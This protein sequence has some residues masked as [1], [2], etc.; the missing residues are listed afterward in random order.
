MR[1]RVILAVLASAAIG[2]SAVPLVASQEI[3]GVCCSNDGH[4]PTAYHCVI[5]IG[6]DCSS[7]QTG[8]C[9]P[10]PR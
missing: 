5:K 4:C 6:V 7:Q 9:E 2:Y 1:L 3:E 10:V 8:Y